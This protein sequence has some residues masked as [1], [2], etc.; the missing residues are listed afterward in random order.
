MQ[1]RIR[2]SARFPLAGVDWPRKLLMGGATG[3]LLE[4]VF[5]GLAYLLSEEAA[6]G[7]APL[8]VGLNFPALGYILQVY[9]GT[10][11]WEVGALP[12]WENWP[13][14]LRNGLAA[15]AVCLAYGVVPLLL[16]LVGLGLLV[17][18]GIL[19]F[20]GMVLMVLGV[21]AGVFMLF[22]L[23]MALARYLAERRIEAAF[24]PA[25]LWEGINA[26]LAEYVATYL[27]SIGAYILASLI[28][29]I[30]Y[31]GGLIWPF[32]WFYLMLVQA[33]LFGEICAKAA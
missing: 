23:P 21:L 29:A 8:V 10:L 25:I 16:L 19:L 31:L 11:L 12:E 17:K 24:H 33:R 32:L 28:A 30:P 5:V 15:F 9:R 2:A 13:A 22:F 26:V 3:L 20:L 18:G 4:L 7:I 27:L 1:L 14:L 6:F